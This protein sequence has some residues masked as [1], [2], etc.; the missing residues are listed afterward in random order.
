MVCSGR[1]VFFSGKSSGSDNPSTPAGA[2]SKYLPGG[3]RGLTWLSCLNAGGGEKGDLSRVLSLKKVPDLILEI[4]RGEMLIRGWGVF[5]SRQLLVTCSNALS[6]FC[7]NHMH[8]RLKL[9][10]SAGPAGSSARGAC[11]W[12]VASAEKTFHQPFLFCKPNLRPD[13][14]EPSAHEDR[15]MFGTNYP[16]YKM[17]YQQ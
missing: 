5:W 4:A 8:T 14:H 9:K 1:C 11:I 3:R 13:W 16:R 6:N 10:F 7:I 17:K 2:L 12:H 15:N